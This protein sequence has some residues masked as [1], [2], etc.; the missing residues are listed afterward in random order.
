MNCSH[1]DSKNTYSRNTT[2]DLGYQEYRCRDC[3]RQFNERTGSVFNYLEYPTE[4]VILTLWYYFDFNN[5]YDDVVRLM[6]QRGV[7][8]CHQTVSN[9]VHTVGVWT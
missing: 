2:T 7:E 3:G 5:G 1:C 8:L 6:A 9:W 4:V